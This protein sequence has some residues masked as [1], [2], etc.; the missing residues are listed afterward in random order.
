MKKEILWNL[1]FCEEA[2]V[3]EAMSDA[4]SERAGSTLI[5]P[6]LAGVANARQT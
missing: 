4:S 3:G 2:D 5:V 6:V 1:P